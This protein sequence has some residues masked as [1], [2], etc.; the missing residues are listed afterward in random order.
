MPE[1]LFSYFESARSVALAIVTNHDWMLVILTG[2]LAIFIA[3]FW[4]STRKQAKILQ[5][6]YIAVEP[7]GVR[8]MQNGTDLSGHAGMKNAGRL[9][10]RKVS[11]YIR[12]DVS[13]SG[14]ERESLFPLKRGSGNIVIAPG[15]IAM[16]GSANSVPAQ[17]LGE[18]AGSEVAS[19]G[20]EKPIYLYVW[21]V[22]R[23]DDGFKRMRMTKF[24]HRYIWVN[25]DQYSRSYEIDASDARYHEYANGA[26]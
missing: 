23:Y 16:L 17:T 15:A 9:P 24:C 20:D 13:E 4:Y 12:I 14:T 10:A 3:V 5:R 19:G 25:R 21:G 2:L 18:Y 22:V 1:N 6:A 11:W 26:D 8:L 7:L